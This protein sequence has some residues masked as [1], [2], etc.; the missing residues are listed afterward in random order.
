MR[1]RIP[2]ATQDE[3]WSDRDQGLH[4][5]WEAPE[6]DE[7]A[8]LRDPV[9]YSAI[10]GP[11]SERVYGRSRSDTGD[12]PF[13][14]YQG[15]ADRDPYGPR[16]RGGYVKRAGPDHGRVIDPTQSHRGRGPRNYQRADDR[17]YADVCEALT[18][19]PEVDATHVEVAVHDCEVTLSGYVRTRS[20]KRRAEDVAER[21]SGIRD[22]HNKLR[23]QS[24]EGA[25]AE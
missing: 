24:S 7:H 11:E 3:Y 8:R 15:A 14:R 23:V 10:G 25:A 20:E 9:D 5:K 6:G 19:D 4:H 22:V 12:Y 2:P 18:D 1:P 17:L 16:E 13:G 21:V